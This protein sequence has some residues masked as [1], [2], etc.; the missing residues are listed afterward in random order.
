MRLGYSALVILSYV[1]Y[2]V[3][4]ID[5]R[6]DEGEEVDSCGL[7]ALGGIVRSPVGGGRLW[8]WE[9]SVLI[10]VIARRMVVMV[11]YDGFHCYRDCKSSFP[12]DGL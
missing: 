9:G 5:A 4:P 10:I 6:G 12:R 8:E 11:I 2:R 7:S 3:N 1:N